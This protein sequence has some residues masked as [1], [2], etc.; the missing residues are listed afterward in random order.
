MIGHNASVFTFAKWASWLLLTRQILRTIDIIQGT[1]PCEA[2]MLCATKGQSPSDTLDWRF[3]IPVSKDF[4]PYSPPWLLAPQGLEPEE[5]GEAGNPS[6]LPC[7]HP[8]PI[9]WWLSFP[10]CKSLENS[11]LQPK[12]YC[13]HFTCDRDLFMFD[14]EL[15]ELSE[16]QDRAWFT[17][18]SSLGSTFVAVS[19]V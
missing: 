12:S 18:I 10:P 8:E 14:L 2:T 17:I 3:T 1:V 9:S 4:Y 11:P 13:R 7:R 19:V 15:I 6:T 16:S 5:V